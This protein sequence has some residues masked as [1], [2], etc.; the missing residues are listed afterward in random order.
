MDYEK[1]EHLLEKLKM[2]TTNPILVYPKVFLGSLYRVNRNYIIDTTK[3]F[4][5]RQFQPKD[6]PAP[7]EIPAHVMKQSSC[8]YV[9]STGRCGT[10]LLTKLLSTNPRIDALHVPAPELLY[11][12]KLTYLFGHEQPECYRIAA[13]HSRYELVKSSYLSGGIF[14][15]TNNRITFYAPFLAEIFKKACFIHLV[16]NP[17]HFVRSGLRRGYY[18]HHSGDEGRIVPRPQDPI[19]KHWGKLSQTEK[20]SWLWNATNQYIEEFKK[21]VGIDRV[22]TIRAEDLFSN[23][24]VTVELFQ[25]IGT[26]S[27][28]TKRI[29]RI[30]SRPTNVQ[31]AGNIPRYED[32]PDSQKE[33]I[34]TYTP[35]ANLYGYKL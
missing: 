21:I 27:I 9:L 2:V 15:E 20:I 5:R 35:L 13:F 31:R 6:L 22:A 7:E 8:C 12:S 24:E 18:C 33:Q 32:W 16:R 30:I 3:K 4:R 19:C 11:Q 34:K 28:P 17:A 10:H 25:F 23:P 26:D 14:V 29:R 1:F